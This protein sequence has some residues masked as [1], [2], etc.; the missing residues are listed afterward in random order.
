MN[1]PKNP[2][3]NAGKKPEP[4]K[5]KWP[6]PLNIRQERF[7]EFVA[8][9]MPDS[10]A[11]IE[12]GYTKSRKN[13][14]ANAKLFQESADKALGSASATVRE[15]ERYDKTI[16]DLVKAHPSSEA[17]VAGKERLTNLKG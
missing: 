15:M 8:R 4:A 2:A 11:Y 7:A 13:A 10:Q 14:E 9:G 12:A 16:D 1:P 5:S 6:K 17:A 3:R